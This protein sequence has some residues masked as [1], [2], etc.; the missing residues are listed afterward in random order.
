MV[1]LSGP[2]LWSRAWGPRAWC[3][4]GLCGTWRPASAPAR[5]PRPS[6]GHQPSFPQ[7]DQINT[8]LNL[9]RS[10]AQ[11]NENMRQ[12][13]ER[14][15]KELKVKLQEME[16]TVKSKYKASITAL[17]AKIAQLEEQL[18]NETK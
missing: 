14:Q 11:K 9:E 10:H 6:W 16:G 5:A 15:N 4:Q 3:F 8:D 17:E 12:Q 18:D 7:I 13:L 2:W 1:S